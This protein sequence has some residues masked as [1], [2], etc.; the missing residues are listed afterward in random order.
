MVGTHR[1]RSPPRRTRQ[2]SRSFPPSPGR[3]GS[4]K[5]TTRGW[6]ENCGFER[7]SGGGRAPVRRELDRNTR[8]NEPSLIRARRRE[9]EQRPVDRVEGSRDDPDPPEPEAEDRVLLVAGVVGHRPVA[10]DRREVRLAG[11]YPVKFAE[12]GGGAGA[13]VP[14]IL[15]PAGADLGVSTAVDSALRLV[16]TAGIG[17]LL[18]VAVVAE[19]E[20]AGRIIERLG[21]GE[22]EGRE[23][24]RPPEVD[25]ETR[26][27]SGTHGRRARIVGERPDVA[28]G[29]DRP[30]ARQPGGAPAEAGHPEVLEPPGERPELVDPERLGGSG[31][32]VLAHGRDDTRGGSLPGAANV[33]RSPVV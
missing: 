1:P 33:R 18:E 12:R 24:R 23:L 19:G 27:L 17:D 4:H 28:V 21:V 26:R 30:A 16:T 20:A 13:V 3:R 2:R 5:P 15:E 32:V 6:R 31:H 10:G 8:P 14:D 25:E 9:L 11:E 22:R 29:L 7:R